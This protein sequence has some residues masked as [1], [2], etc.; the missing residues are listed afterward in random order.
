MS[1][2]S[3]TEREL[4]EAL[5]GEHDLDPIIEWKHG[6]AL[7][8]SESGELVT[9]E[10]ARV[11]HAADVPAAFEFFARQS[12]I[13]NEGTSESDQCTENVDRFNEM[14][15]AALRRSASA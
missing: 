10:G 14:V 6:A 5:I 15:C 8:F 1:S 4:I 3:L 12:R 13:E 7:C 9:I 2:R 11:E